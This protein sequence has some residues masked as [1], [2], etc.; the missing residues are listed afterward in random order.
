MKRYRRHNCVARH[1]THN[2]MAQC[3]WRRTEIDG[4]GPYAT[5]AYCGGQTTVIL[6]P[7]EAAAN[8]ALLLI[9]PLGGGSRCVGNHDLVQLVLPIPAN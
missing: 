9:G 4:E 8:E 3:I 6:H 5:I 2:A 7:T 1:Q